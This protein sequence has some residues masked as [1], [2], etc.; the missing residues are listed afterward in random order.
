MY[1]FGIEYF[2]IYPVD[3]EVKGSATAPQ[4]NA[5][6]ELAAKTALEAMNV[7]LE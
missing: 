4:K 1:L 5:A 7:N 6:K 3:G 2:F